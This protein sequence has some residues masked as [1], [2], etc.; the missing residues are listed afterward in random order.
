[1]KHSSMNKYIDPK[2]Q[3]VQIIHKCQMQMSI[4]ID[5]E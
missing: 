3:Q 4:D 1:M 5:C 2:V